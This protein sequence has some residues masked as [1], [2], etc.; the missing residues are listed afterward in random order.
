MLQEDTGIMVQL[1]IF[2]TSEQAEKDTLI[3]QFLDVKKSADAVRRGLFARHN[4]VAKIVRDLSDRLE[5]IEKH[6]C[7]QEDKQFIAM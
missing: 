1:D 2:K 6:I 4:E 7:K 3:K 5:I